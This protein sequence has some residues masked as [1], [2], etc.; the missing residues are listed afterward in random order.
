MANII[1]NIAGMSNMTEQVI[2][3]DFLI[4]AKNGVVNYATALTEASTPQ[5]RDILKRHLND[6]VNI[7]E[8]IS[9][10]MIQKGYYQAYNPTEMINKDLEASN[11]VLGL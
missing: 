9:F 1:Q 7:H 3:T 2:A 6:A 10:Y 5:V 11:I 8:R 4:S